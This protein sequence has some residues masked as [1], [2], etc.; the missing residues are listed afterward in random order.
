MSS[1]QKSSIFRDKT[2]FQK[3]EMISWN[4]SRERPWELSLASFPGNLHHHIPATSG[5]LQDFISGLVLFNT[6]M[7]DLML[8]LELHKVCW[9]HLSGRSC[10]LPQQ[11]NPGKPKGRAITN[12]KKWF[13]QGKVMGS[14]PGIGQ[15][16]MGNKRLESSSAG[17]D[18]GV[19]DDGKLSE[20]CPGSQEGLI[21]SPSARGRTWG[22]ATKLWQGKFRLEKPG[23]GSSPGVW[24]GTRKGSPMEWCW[25]QTCQNAKSIWTMLPSTWR[26]SWGCPVYNQLNFCDACGS[27]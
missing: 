1:M 14:V 15:P 21:F 12:H 7:N 18:L 22:N 25:H 2:P 10:C 6:L 11:I 4:K 5:D 20:H 9:Q 23:N 27:L 3:C 16:W 17:R 24:S 8:G 13:Q 19:L 26:H